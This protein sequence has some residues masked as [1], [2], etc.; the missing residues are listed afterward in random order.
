MHYNRI[1]VLVIILNICVASMITTYAPLSLLIAAQ[2]NF[3]IAILGRN[4]YLVNLMSRLAVRAPVH[5]PLDVRWALAKVYHVGG[6]HV[7]AALSGTAWYLA[8][9]LAI[10][11][12]A[13]TY[14][15]SVSMVNLALSLA[16]I[17]LILGIIV[18]AM[19]S[20]RE[21][22][23]DR[24]ELS[25]RFFGWT[26]LVL[27]LTNTLTFALHQFSSGSASGRVQTMVICSLL[28]VSTA[29]SLTPWFGLRKVRIAVT[30]P[31]SHA[32][33]VDLH[34]DVTPMVGSVRAISRNP[35]FGWH[36]FACVRAS[37]PAHGYR[38]VVSRAGDWTGEFIDRPPSHVW[39]RGIPVAG[40]A[41][42]RK[43]FRKVVFVATGS[44]IFPL[45][46]HLHANEVSSHMVWVTRNPRKTY[47][48][49]L[50]DEI[51]A[52][53][54]SITIWDSDEDGRPDV[55]QLAYSAYMQHHAE[56]VI[57]VANRKITWQVVYGL[58]QR[59]IPAFGP[60]WD[61]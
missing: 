7:G 17:T 12:K 35:F 10:V 45:L 46:T 28:L 20:M 19:P 32:A 41:N 51:L 50:V 27:A 33:L 26:A 18:M 25:H 40:M 53:Q 55:L 14:S 21:R 24:F 36:A 9:V 52:S 1:A 56:A 34:H 43:L 3:S 16:F 37:D 11:Q 5:W 22:F 31:S 2:A 23:H 29:S 39:V 49:A 42:V 30:S 4:Q 44:G 13:R 54:K 57:C 59:A 15:G 47:G 61:S 38:M 60:I 8:F 48:D 58:E 6:L